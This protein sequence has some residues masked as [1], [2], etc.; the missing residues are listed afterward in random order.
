M[1]NSVVLVAELFRDEEK[2]LML[3]LVNM[4][5]LVERAKDGTS[6]VI[7]K[8]KQMEIFKNMMV[9]Y[10]LGYVDYE[11]IDSVFIDAGAGGKPLPPYKVICK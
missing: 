9:D 6:M 2:G 5:N 7:Q 4:V 3:K 8:P 11:G 10:N 1:D